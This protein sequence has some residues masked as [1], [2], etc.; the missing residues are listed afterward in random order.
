MIN[1]LSLTFD[2]KNWRRLIVIERG[3]RI[4]NVFGK[5]YPSRR[6]LGVPNN[7][8]PTPN[9]DWTIDKII[10]IIISSEK[11]ITSNS[12]YLTNIQLSI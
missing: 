10:I 6:K 9:T 3:M 11:F 4:F 12:S 7:N 8:N 2:L 5:S 1:F